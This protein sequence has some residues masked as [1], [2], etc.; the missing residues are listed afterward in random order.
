MQINKIQRQPVS[1]GIYKVANVSNKNIMKFEDTI[2]PLYRTSTKKSIRAIN[3]GSKGF[4]TLTE[5]DAVDFDKYHGHIKR[6]GI[7][8]FNELL[9]DVSK[10]MSNVVKPFSYTDHKYTE[11]FLYGRKIESVD[12]FDNLTAKLLMK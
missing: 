3:A 11:E 8:F 4:Y 9:D 6:T 1:K 10:A 7:A 5:K 12:S 2:A